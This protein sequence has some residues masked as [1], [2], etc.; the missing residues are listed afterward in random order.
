MARNSNGANGL[1]AWNSGRIVPMA[2]MIA[3]KKRTLACFVSLW[4]RHDFERDP[5]L[6]PGIQAARIQAS[7]ISAI[8]RQK[9]TDCFERKNYIA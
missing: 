3:N 1:R 8:G 2:G 6:A 7:G 5:G 9:I 4:R